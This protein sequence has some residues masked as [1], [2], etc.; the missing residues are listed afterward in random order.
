MVHSWRR[1]ILDGRENGF[2]IFCIMIFLIWRSLISSV[3]FFGG[4]GIFFF[5]LYFNPIVHLDT[6]KTTRE[7]LDYRYQC[8]DSPFRV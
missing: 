7:V 1:F 8:P 5:S 3:F 4:G 6:G 2:C